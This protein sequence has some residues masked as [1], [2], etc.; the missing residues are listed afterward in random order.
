VEMNAGWDSSAA[1]STL[2]GG[3]AKTLAGAVTGIRITSVGGTATFDAGK[4]NVQYE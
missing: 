1:A 3:G 2:N 4:V